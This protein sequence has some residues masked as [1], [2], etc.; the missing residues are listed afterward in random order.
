MGVN[1]SKQ[2]M[3]VPDRGHDMCKTSAGGQT[4]HDAWWDMRGSQAD[5]NTESTG[6]LMQEM[7]AEAGGDQTV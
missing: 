2:R 6:R 5:V 4:E 1:Q 7:A 3:W